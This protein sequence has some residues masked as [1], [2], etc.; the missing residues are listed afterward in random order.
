VFRDNGQTQG[1]PQYPPTISHKFVERGHLFHTGSERLI[2]IRQ[3]IVG[4]RRAALRRGGDIP[5]PP[6]GPQKGILL[7][8]PFFHVTGLTSL[9]VRLCLGHVPK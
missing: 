1:R 9:T 4:G 5:A 7:S 3:V 6:V 8:V 2:D